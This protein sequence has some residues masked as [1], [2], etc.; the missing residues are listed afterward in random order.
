MRLY[1]CYF[2]LYALLVLSFDHVK[3][4]LCWYHSMLTE[5][6]FIWFISDNF[7]TE[8]NK[9]CENNHWTDNLDRQWQRRRE[10]W[11]WCSKKNGSGTEK[12]NK[13]LNDHERQAVGWV[14][15]L[16]I[17]RVGKQT[18]LLQGPEKLREIFASEITSTC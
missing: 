4:S 5:L 2:T 16:N 1:L 11:S 13:T 3:C 14:I 8:S 6:V 9:K 10:P 12:Y 7:L 15:L 17:F 18:Y